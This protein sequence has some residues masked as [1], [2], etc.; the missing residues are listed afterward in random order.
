MFVVF[1]FFMSLCKVCFLR[2]H[3]S[4]TNGKIIKIVDVISWVFLTQIKLVTPFLKTILSDVSISEKI[5]QIRLL[6]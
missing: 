5:K 1:S 6:F 2:E 4:L 3:G